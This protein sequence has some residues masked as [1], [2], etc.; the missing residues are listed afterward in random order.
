MTA[1]AMKCPKCGAQLTATIEGAG[2]RESV[3]ALCPHCGE[4]ASLGRP[5]WDRRG[6]RAHDW[7]MAGFTLLGLVA[8]VL[9]SFSLFIFERMYADFGTTLPMLT[10]LTLHFWLPAIFAAIAVALVAGGITLRV[11]AIPG[12]RWLFV[13]AIVTAFGGAVLCLAALYLP[14]FALAGSVR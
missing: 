13:A 9:E 5:T 8:L 14:V 2:G 3:F 4:R 7:V 11:K 12:G 6:M 10:E 1:E